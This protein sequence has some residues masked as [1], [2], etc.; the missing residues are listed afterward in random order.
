MRWEIDPN[1]KITYNAPDLNADDLRRLVGELNAVNAFNTKSAALATG[2][3]DDIGM[4]AKVGAITQ[5]E[6]DAAYGDTTYTT[7]QVKGMVR[8]RLSVS[9]QFKII[10]TVRKALVGANLNPAIELWPMYSAPM[11]MQNIGFSGGKCLKLMAAIEANPAMT[12]FYSD[13][14]YEPTFHVVDSP[15]TASAPI[16][17]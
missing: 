16:K 17:W 14:T 8:M 1:V 2:F 15:F 11:I 12:H 13:S 9:T 7:L 4:L 3:V 5:A 10:T 6:L